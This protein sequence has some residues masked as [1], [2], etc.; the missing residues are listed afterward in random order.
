[1]TKSF[2][3]NAKFSRPRY[4]S[5]RHSDDEDISEYYESSPKFRDT[6][7]TLPEINGPAKRVMS[8]QEESRNSM[9]NMDISEVIVEDEPVIKSQKSFKVH[10]IKSY[11]F[12]RDHAERMQELARK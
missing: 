8:A 5:C 10:V 2:V 3:S 1:M 11:D 4:A 9:G 6:Q 12:D 7:L